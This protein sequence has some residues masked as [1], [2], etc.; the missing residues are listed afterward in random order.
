MESSERRGLD[1]EA[2]PRPVLVNGVVPG[3]GRSLA[4]DRQFADFEWAVSKS[5]KCSLIIITLLAPIPNFP[6]LIRDHVCE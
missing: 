5:Q 1:G 6:Y 4:L 2:I 3:T